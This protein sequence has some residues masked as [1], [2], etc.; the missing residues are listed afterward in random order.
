M[1][2]VE[3]AHLADLLDATKQAQDISRE[4]R[5][6]SARTKKAVWDHT[7]EK[8]IFAYETNGGC[9]TMYQFRRLDVCF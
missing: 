1:L 5:V 3:L 7:V 9:L 2:S 8:N 4:A 6:W